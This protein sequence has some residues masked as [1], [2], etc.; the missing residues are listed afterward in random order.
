VVNRRC[1]ISM[2][3]VAV[4]VSYEHAYA[5]VTHGETEWTASPDPIDRGRPDSSKVVL[6]SGRRSVPVPWL[7][8]WLLGLG[9]AAALAAQV[10]HG[11]GTV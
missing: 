1:R 3:V 11:L 4:M 5:L 9:I 6:D 8:Q 2:A 7:A 10:A